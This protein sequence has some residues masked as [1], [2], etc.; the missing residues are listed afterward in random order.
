MQSRRRFLQIGL[1]W[2]GD[3]PWM[4][5]TKTYAFCLGMCGLSTAAMAL[6]IRTYW[7]LVVSC[8]LFGIFFASTFSFTPVILV[9]LIPL[10]RFTL[11]YGLILMCQGIGNLLGPPIAGQQNRPK[12]GRSPYSYGAPI[13]A[14][15]IFASNLFKF[16]PIIVLERGICSSKI[17][18]YSQISK[19]QIGGGVKK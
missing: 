1:G 6:F 18:L 11:A 8:A 12:I 14:R 13:F 17:V 19:T 2:A 16:L 4:N 9:Q 7:A 5:V 10:E 3:Q 15:V